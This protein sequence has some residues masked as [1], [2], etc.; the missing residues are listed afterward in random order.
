MEP[1]HQAITDQYRKIA[2]YYDASVLL[3]YLAG[4]RVERYRRLAVAALQ[5][6]PGDTAVELGCGTGANLGYLVQAVGPAGRVIGVDLTDAM[7][8]QAQQRVERQ[9]WTN[10]EL[11]HSDLAQYE[12]PAD[13]GGVLSTLCITLSPDYD[14]VIQ[15]AGAALRPGG[16]LAILD[17]RQPEHWPRWLVRLA[18]WLQSP[19]CVRQELG[20]RTPWLSVQ[21]HLRKVLHREFFWGCLYLSVGRAGER[22]V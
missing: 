2:R 22:G 9:G 1:D 12:V 8:A 16:R 17:L 20:H 15:R 10:V 3:Y 19:Y 7:L 4:V 14:Q 5:L 11:V 6:Q 18:A 13:T 21:R